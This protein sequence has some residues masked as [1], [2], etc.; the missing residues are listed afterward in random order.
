[1]NFVSQRRAWSPD[2][3][4]IAFEAISEE[5][6]D[7]FVVSADG[8]K[9]RKL[10]SEFPEDAVPRWSRDGR[11]IYYSSTRSG[12]FQIWKVPTEG[13]ETRQVT[14]EILSARG[15]RTFLGRLARSAGKLGTQSFDF[16]FG[17]QSALF[18]RRN[19]AAFSIAPTQ[20]GVLLVLEYALP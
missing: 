16:G 6:R 1:M 11:W 7:I 15:I 13:G 2:G 5:Q 9:P 12:N 20:P 3:R 17:L 8:G 14:T 10:T 4:Q 18:A 19:Q